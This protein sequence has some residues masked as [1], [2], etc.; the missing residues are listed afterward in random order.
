M[1][2]EHWMSELIEIVEARTGGY[3]DSFKS[4]IEDSLFGL[5]RIWVDELIDCWV[6]LSDVS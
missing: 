3:F 1:E 6:E 5:L 2:G 4:V